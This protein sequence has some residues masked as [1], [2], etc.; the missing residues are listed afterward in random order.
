[1]KPGK[2]LPRGT[3]AL[4]R[5]ARLSRAGRLNPV[6]VKRR[7]ENRQRHAMAARLWPDG[8]PLLAAGAQYLNNENRE[9]H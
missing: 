8:P 5:T 1:M 9:S 7:A 6:S 3:Q 2:P 4:T